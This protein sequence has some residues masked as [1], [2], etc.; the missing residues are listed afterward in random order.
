MRLLAFGLSLLLEDP[1]SNALEP[2]TPKA[3]PTEIIPDVNGGIATGSLF[4]ARLYFP[5]ES[6]ADSE[7]DIS[8]SLAALALS[9]LSFGMSG[10]LLSAFL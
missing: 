2:R 9:V 4:S 3:F 8:L 1:K 10:N 7:I 5:L 6:L